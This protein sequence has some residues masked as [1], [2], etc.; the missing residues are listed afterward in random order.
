MKALVSFLLSASLVPAAVIIGYFGYALPPTI[1]NELD[2][3]ALARVFSGLRRLCS[4]VPGLSPRLFEASTAPNVSEAR[5]R[6][7]KGLERFLLGLSDQ[8]LV[9]GLS[10]LTTGY[11][12]RC[13]MTLYHFNIV[14]ALAWFSSAVHL[15]TLGTLREYFI[16]N[17]SV[18]NWRVAG[19]IGVLGMLLCAQIA[20]YSRNDYS[21]PLQSVLEAPLYVDS[22]QLLSVALIWFFLL[23]LYM[24]RIVR[25]FSVDPDWS[26]SDWIVRS[27]FKRKRRQLGLTNPFENAMSLLSIVQRGKIIRAEREIRRFRQHQ[28]FRRRNRNSRFG[29][30]ENAFILVIVEF[31]DSF[32]SQIST[33]FAEIIY[34]VDATIV[35]RR[36]TP[37]HGISGS[38][39]TMGFGQVM[40]VFLLLLPCFTIY[41]L[42]IGKSY[43][44]YRTIQAY[45]ANQ[46][47]MSNLALHLPK[48]TEISLSG[49][50]EAI[51]EH[52]TTVAPSA[53]QGRRYTPSLDEA[54]SRFSPPVPCFEGLLLSFDASEEASSS[55]R[56][57]TLQCASG[58]V[59]ISTPNQADT[60][61]GLREAQDYQSQWPH[62][63][64]LSGPYFPNHSQA[65][66]VTTPAQKASIAQAS[67]PSRNRRGFRIRYGRVLTSLVLIN[68]LLSVLFVM[69]VNGH[70]GWSGFLEAV[71][72]YTVLVAVM[73]MS[74]LTR[75]VNDFK[76]LRTQQ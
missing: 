42:Y 14:A 75:V 2:H 73:L 68:V 11:M 4:C 3:L 19:M 27:F 40:P 48:K 44:C 7:R 25:L 20:A 54:P 69:C 51:S 12:Q 49:E 52:D 58:S 50:D 23:T 30:Y 59:Q 38:Q 15:A 53:I 35:L 31:S 36:N 61:F 1:L 46:N 60:G 16:E 64:L 24:R 65:G 5:Q 10:V 13:S 21:L 9:T 29:V 33:L 39:N 70:F 66:D 67:N 37:P 72:S 71:I 8:Q 17:P 6:R 28:E 22:S 18:R 26:L 34:G 62:G 55:S 47:L 41:E 32:L 74:I 43:E 56:P 57:I 76:E 45:L 63:S